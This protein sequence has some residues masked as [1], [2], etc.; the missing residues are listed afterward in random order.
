MLPVF[1]LWQE[2]S[3]A[4]ALPGFLNPG[5][6]AA[7]PGSLCLPVPIPRSFLPDPFQPESAR[8]AYP[9]LSDS[10]RASRLPG[11]PLPDP[12]PGSAIPVR[13]TLSPCLRIFFLSSSRVFRISGNSIRQTSGQFFRLFSA[14]PAAGDL[15][16]F[17]QKIRTP[18]FCALQRLPAARHSSIFL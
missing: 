11:F 7:P 13:Q 10:G 4:S 16:A 14:I 9:P 17:V 18:L 8:P 1:F 12:P 2:P 6:I 3:P 5:H 15:E